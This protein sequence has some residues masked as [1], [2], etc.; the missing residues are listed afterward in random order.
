MRWKR[1]D[2]YF[3]GKEIFCAKTIIN[4]SLTT[5]KCCCSRQSIQICHR[6]CFQQR[7]IIFNKIINDKDFKIKKKNFFTI[8]TC[9]LDLYQN[10]KKVLSS[11]LQSPKGTIN[12]FL[13]SFIDHLLF[14]FML[15]KQ[16]KKRFLRNHNYEKDIPKYSIKYIAIFVFIPLLNIVGFIIEYFVK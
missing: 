16:L 5:D 11:W 13:L 12:F 8:F 4:N 3:F 6:K 1:N 9:C 2:K 14:T 10:V 15:K 7:P